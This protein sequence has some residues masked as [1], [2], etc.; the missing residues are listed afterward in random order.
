MKNGVFHRRN[1]SGIEKFFNEFAAV[2]RELDVR[3]ADLFDEIG[4]RKM[5]DDVFCSGLFLSHRFGRYAGVNHIERAAA[6]ARYF[7]DFSEKRSSGVWLF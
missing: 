1:F 2:R 6:L 7:V 3:F 5:F 4:L